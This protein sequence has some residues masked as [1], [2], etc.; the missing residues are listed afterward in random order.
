MEAVRLSKLFPLVGGLASGLCLMGLVLSES[1]VGVVLYFLGMVIWYGCNLWARTL[2]RFLRIG[3]P[4]VVT[5]LC[6]V[7]MSVDKTAQ[8]VSSFASTT[9]SEPQLGDG[10]RWSIYQDASRMLLDAPVTGFGLGSF[11]VV[12]PQYREASASFEPVLQPESDFVWLA[13]EGGL[14]ALGFLLL[15][16]LA[17]AL[18]CRG[19]TQ[20]MS[21]SY[22]VLAFAPVL[23]FFFHSL[24][25]VSGHSPG[26]MYLAIL[27]AALALPGRRRSQSYISLRLWRMLGGLLML[28]GVIWLLAGTFGWIYVHWIGR[29]IFNEPSWPC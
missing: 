19:F 18:R 24:I 21:A 15:V 17:Y 6:L 27:F 2:P 28:F 8:G 25:D 16:L 26:A 7:V 11:S 5:M 29:L 3:F 10:V 22:R 13:T 9:T 23:L 20:G 1:R 4:I 14:L 12:F